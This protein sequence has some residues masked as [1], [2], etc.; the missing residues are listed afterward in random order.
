MKNLLTCSKIHNILVSSYTKGVR[1][2]AENKSRAD[3]FKE[4]RRTSK[5]FY[6]EIERGKMEAFEEKLSQEDKT[7]K[8][9][10]NEKIDDELRK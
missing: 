9:W 2:L 7:K 3:Y 1:K 8:E 6:V 4:R 5:A 10:L